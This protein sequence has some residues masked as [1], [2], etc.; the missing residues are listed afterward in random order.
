MS[1]RSH[2]SQQSRRAPSVQQ[3]STPHQPTPGP[4]NLRSPPANE[5]FNVDPTESYFAAAGNEQVSSP[6]PPAGYGNRTV[7]DFVGGFN[8]RRAFGIQ[9]PPPPP[10]DDS[11]TTTSS[12]SS[13][14]SPVPMPQPVP[15]QATPVIPAQPI[16][17]P[18]VSRHSRAIQSQQIPYESPSPPS[19]IGHENTLEG[20]TAIG[21][22]EPIPPRTDGLPVHMSPV[23]L[24]GPD[25]AMMNTPPREYTLKGFLS[26]MHSFFKE[27]ND[28]PWIADRVTADFVPGQPV[29]RLNYEKRP[30]SSATSNRARPS[31]WYGQPGHAE[32]LDLTRGMSPP[33]A[34]ANPYANVHPQTMAM[35]MT[36]AAQPATGGYIYA[37]APARSN[38]PY[39]VHNQ[40][41]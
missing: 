26:R 18:P 19:D 30:H 21:H 12:S 34:N 11:T 39:P 35:S 10:K 23:L 5:T 9:R 14:Y 16:K 8:F 27:L 33:Q 15:A 24:P 7:R 3:Q 40:H 22:Y 13:S 4:S 6:P 32:S 28:L 36:A 31:T 41:A 25:Y 2:R 1:P 37:P 38:Y 17:P 29:H 20:T